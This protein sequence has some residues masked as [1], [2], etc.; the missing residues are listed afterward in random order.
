MQ[1]RRKFVRLDTRLP[2]TYEVMPGS[3]SQPSVT[4]DIG[5]GGVCVFLKEPLKPGARLRVK[6][7]LPDQEAAIEFTAEIAWCEQYEVIGKT[8]RERS[9][10]AGVR[11]LEVDPA[12]QQALMRHCILQLKPHQ[13]T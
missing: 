1:E 3:P 9:I 7:K 13:P 12:D 10:E 8:R 4:K 11:F 6:I 5:G 2:V